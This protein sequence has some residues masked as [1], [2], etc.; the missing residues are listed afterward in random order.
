MGVLLVAGSESAYLGESL[1][2]SLMINLL[3]KSETT[4]FVGR[5][6]PPVIP[7]TG[8][9]PVD[10]GWGNGQVGY[11][12]ALDLPLV[13]SPEASGNTGDYPTSKNS[14]K[15]SVSLLL[16]S[17]TLSDYIKKIPFGSRNSP[18]EGDVWYLI[19]FP[20]WLPILP[21]QN[22]LLPQFF[23]SNKTIHPVPWVMDIMLF[24]SVQ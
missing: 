9:Q 6:A 12:A 22:Y 11:G 1:G 13:K 4:T 19:P 5:L 15:N 17:I 24:F 18:Y 21:T 16:I 8:T 7:A 23:P 2:F 20:V 10:Q 14:E 3:A